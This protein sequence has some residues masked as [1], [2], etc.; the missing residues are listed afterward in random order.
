MKLYMTKA[1]SEKWIYYYSQSREKELIEEETGCSETYLKLW[2][3][4]QSSKHFEDCY[5]YKPS[6]DFSEEKYYS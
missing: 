6:S 5:Q 3:F 2:K 1:E 4:I